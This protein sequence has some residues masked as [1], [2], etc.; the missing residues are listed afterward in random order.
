MQHFEPKSWRTIRFLLGGGGGGGGGVGGIA[1]G[2]EFVFIC[3]ATKLFF[4]SEIAVNGF[5]FILTTAIL[6]SHI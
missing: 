1:V 4:S 5:F 2:S 6:F 3:Q